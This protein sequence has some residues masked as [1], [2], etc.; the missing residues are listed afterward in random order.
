M[1]KVTPDDHGYAL[2]SNDELRG[3]I[4]DPKIRFVVNG[5]SHRIMVRHFPELTIVNAGTLKAD[6]D[7]GC[8]LIDFGAEEVS[9]Y[10]WAGTGFEL[11]RVDELR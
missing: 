3:L 2:D 9:S 10:T 8:L 7:P 6:N 11:G 1:A 4:A 5:H